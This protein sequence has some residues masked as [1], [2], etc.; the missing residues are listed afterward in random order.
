MAMYLGTIDTSFGARKAG[1]FSQQGR[2]GSTGHSNFEMTNF[3]FPPLLFS[4][5]LL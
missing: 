2:N 5:F 3:P 4:G 1:T